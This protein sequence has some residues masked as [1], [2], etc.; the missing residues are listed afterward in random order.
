MLV[1]VLC[2][3]AETRLDCGCLG[4]HNQWVSFAG[5]LC[6]WSQGTAVWTIYLRLGS[7]I[8]SIHCLSCFTWWCSSFHL[9]Q[10]R[11]IQEIF[12]HRKLKSQENAVSA[13]NNEFSELYSCLHKPPNSMMAI[14]QYFK[15]M[16]HS[17]GSSISLNIHIQTKECSWFEIYRLACQCCTELH[18]ISQIM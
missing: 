9:V 14:D 2:Y 16:K 4:N 15:K 7:C 10:H 18:F 1:Y 5:F 17:F 8:Y 3:F 6:F 11:T 12:C 13:G